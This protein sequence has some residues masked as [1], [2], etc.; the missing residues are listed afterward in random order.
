MQEQQSEKSDLG[1]R[2]FSTIEVNSPGRKHRKSSLPVSLMAVFLLT[3]AGAQVAN[4]SKTGRNG[5]RY[6]FL[7]RKEAVG[8]RHGKGKTG[9]C[10]QHG[11]LGAG[12]GNGT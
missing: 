3:S 7:I 8:F 6:R 4:K 9:G 12:P 2:S 1:S 5:V 11:L 10:R